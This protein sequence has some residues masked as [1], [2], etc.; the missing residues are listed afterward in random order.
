MG[1]V[2]KLY[3]QGDVTSKPKMYALGRVVI[4]SN[5]KSFDSSKVLKI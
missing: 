2:E 3:K 5:H 1:F 4:W